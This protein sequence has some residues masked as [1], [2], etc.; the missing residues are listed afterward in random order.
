[1][2]SP[3]SAIDY[4]SRTKK[5][6]DIQKKRKELRMESL[7]RGFESRTGTK[8]KTGSI[9][10]TSLG[11]SFI[12]TDKGKDNSG[13]KSKDVYSHEKDINIPAVEEE[14]SINDDLNS[15]SNSAIL[16]PPSNI[17]PSNGNRRNAMIL[18]D[19]RRGT[20]ATGD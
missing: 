13:Q 1:L 10:S 6:S 7:H 19:S 8:I 15:L 11:D 4:D 3:E 12:A 20:Q 18:N 5:L 17:P 2:K 9:T 16:S 14:K